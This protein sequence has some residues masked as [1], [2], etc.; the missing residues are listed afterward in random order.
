M[1]SSVIY[2]KTGKGA[3]AVTAKNKALSAQA[4]RL[5]SLVDGKSGI[6]DLMAA[7]EN[8]SEAQLQQ[9]LT[10]LEDE[11]YIRSIDEL[12]MSS[13]FDIRSPIEVAEISPEEFMRIQIATEG[14]DDAAKT[15]EQQEAELRARAIADAAAFQTCL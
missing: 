12:A 13:D 6:A 10:Q 1:N 5:L 2:S 15:R 3:R 8:S 11:G 7:T 14:E 4:L 9:I